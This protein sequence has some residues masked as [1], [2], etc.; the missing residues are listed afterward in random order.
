[1]GSDAHPATRPDRFCGFQETTLLDLEDP[2]GEPLRT[3]LNAKHRAAGARMVAFAGW[4]M[5]V[6]YAGGIQ[7]EAKCVRERAGLFDLQHMGRLRLTGP[8]RAAALDKF[9]TNDVVG[10]GPGL[11]RYAVLTN[12]EGT[13]IDDAIYYVLPEAILL[14]VNASNRDAV[15]DWMRPRLEGD[16]SLTDETDR[17]AMLA[18]QGP[19]ASAVLQPLIDVDLAEVKYYTCRAA[20]V[21]GEPCFLARTGYTGEVGYELVFDATQSEYMWDGILAHGQAEGVEPCGLG[22]RDA[23]RL[24]AGMALYGHELDSETNPLEAGLDFAIK[25][26]EGDFFGRE[27]LRKVKASGPARKL[28]GFTVDGPRIARQGATVL[29]D[30]EPRGKVT[31]GTKSPTLGTVICIAYVAAEVADEAEGWEVEISGKRFPLVPAKLPF[32]SRTRKKKKKKKA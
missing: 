11:A 25:L 26:D 19:R 24:E 10:T 9:L 3:A 30:G 16:V 18:L 5:P 6:Q 28:K 23:L 2:V 14:V 4:D 8:D 15:L 31:S 21:L 27:A 20:M 29:H 32:Y 1:L 13:A 12:E 7:A 22:S 17:W